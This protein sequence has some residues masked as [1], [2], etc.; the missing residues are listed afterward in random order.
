MKTKRMEVTGQGFEDE[1]PHRSWQAF[2]VVETVDGEDR[3]IETMIVE[4]LLPAGEFRVSRAEFP[5]AGLTDHAYNKAGYAGGVTETI[6]D[7]K[8]WGAVKKRLAANW[9]ITEIRDFVVKARKLDEAAR[10]AKKA[11]TR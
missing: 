9:G 7:L 3:I 5:T 11:R 6:R 4:R 10:V 8:S 2:Q 1:G